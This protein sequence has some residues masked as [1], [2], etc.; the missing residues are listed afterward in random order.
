MATSLPTYTG[1]VTS[2]VTPTG[3]TVVDAII[4]GS[5]WGTGGAGTGASVSYSFPTSVAVFDTRPGVAG[6][7]NATEPVGAGFHAYLAGFSPFSAAQQEAARQVLQAFAN[8]A[9]LSFGEVPAG[10]VDAG[11]LRFANSAPP[12]LAANVWG[13]SWFP[14][15]LAGAGDTW[16]N[17][18]F[19][20]PEGWAPGTQ[21]Y[22]TLLH[23]VGHALGLKHPHDRGLSGALTGWPDNPAVLPFTGVDTL[24]SESTQSMVMAY[25]DIPG[26]GTLG[27][28]ALQSDYA[29]T[30]PMRW[31]IAALQHLYG[32]N[33]AYNAGDTVYTFD[34]SARY[35]QT[36]WDG[37]GIDT[38][39]AT[40]P[41]DVEI[42][43]R[44]AQWSKLGQPMSFSTRNA[45]NSVNAPQPQFN[46]PYTVFIYDTVTIENA[47]GSSGNDVLYANSVANRLE[48]AGGIDTA[49]YAVARST[50]TAGRAGTDWSVTAGPGDVDALSGVE[51]LRFT[52]KALAL[53][54]AADGNAGQVA[55]IIRA[56]FGPA[57]VNNPVFVGIGLD[58]RDKGMAYA[59]LVALAISTSIFA[60]LAGSRSNT[61]F[62]RLVYKNVI[63]ADAP[64]DALAQFVGLLDSGGQTQASLG[65]MASQIELNSQAADLVGLISSGL[66]YLP[67]G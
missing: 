26:R 17:S 48:G 9:N 8:V 58:L 46:D 7:Y 66:E 5:K 63:G 31:D 28:L 33:M 35:N 21:N 45:D 34:G 64:P 65:V 52:D 50:I 54:T 62:V 56:L 13:A 24:T 19:L 53:D 49:V 29:P 47:I 14:Q 60:Q 11:T 6:N 18:A 59:D 10:T 22:L 4:G 57:S 12:G 36:I 16:M 42:D 2:L 41:R 15:D 32:P 44:P 1:D 23:E 51:R 55:Q 37:G 43:L 20:F 27:D 25:N 3:R 38:I 30:T 40:G 61:D 39:V 67:A